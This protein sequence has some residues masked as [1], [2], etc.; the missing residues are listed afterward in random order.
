MNKSFITVN[1][2]SKSF[3]EKSIIKNL[4]FNINKGDLVKISGSNGA[5]K[6]T[7]LK[8]IA[9]IYNQDSGEI[10]IGG[11]NINK[12]S[13][14]KSMVSY[15]SSDSVFYKDLTVKKN[16]I[17]YFNL[18]GERKS[19]EIYEKNKHFLK[20]SEF[21]D[22]YPEI[23]S[24]GQKKKMNLFRTLIPN[25]DI[26]LIDEPENG[27]DGESKKELDQKLNS[28][29]NESTIIYTS[30]NSNSLSIYKKTTKEILL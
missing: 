10:K 11:E 16:I 13:L 21:E 3:N 8:I 6:S 18:I 28:L 14:S 1:N 4:S 17:F 29:S 22:L 23:L 26:Y 19:K 7:L 2:I 27:L 15:V 30:H 20:L 12:S 24:N 9:R 25:Y 5:G